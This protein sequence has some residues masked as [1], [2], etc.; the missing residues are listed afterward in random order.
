MAAPGQSTPALIS[1]RRDLQIFQSLRRITRAIDVH[2]RKLKSQFKITAPQLVCLLAVANEGPL[3]ATT[4]ARRVFLSASTVVGILDRLEQRGL[5][6][7]IRDQRD[8]RLVRVS[9]TAEGNQLALTAPPPLQDGLA[10]ALG[11][12]TEGEQATIADS[13]SR[14]GDL[15]EI[16]DADSPASHRAEFETGEHSKEGRSPL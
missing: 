2:S 14:I 16:T 13:L 10:R 12:L 11:Q 15:M 5:V 6:R 4:I 1:T 8:R 9:A 3:T 7:R